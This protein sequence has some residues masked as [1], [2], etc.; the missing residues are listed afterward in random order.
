MVSRN[1]KIID[2]KLYERAKDLYL[3]AFYRVNYIGA[4]NSVGF[5]NPSEAG[6]ICSDAVAFAMTSQSLLRQALV[7]EGVAVP[8]DVNLELNKYVHNRGSKKLPFKSD[9]E[10]KD[11]FGLQDQLTPAYGK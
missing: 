11:P 9:V 3:E 4:E 10:F 1:G 7:Q 2:Q 8:A 5:H 6:R